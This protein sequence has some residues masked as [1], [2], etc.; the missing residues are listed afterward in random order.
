MARELDL[1]R[2]TV[3]RCLGQAARGTNGPGDRYKVAK[4]IQTEPVFCGFGRSAHSKVM[5]VSVQRGEIVTAPRYVRSKG[6]TGRV[7]RLLW[8]MARAGS[9]PVP[10]ES[11][12]APRW[13]SGH[14]VG[15]SLARDPA[16]YLGVYIRD[17][18]SI[19][20]V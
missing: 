2:K 18:P 10:T 9:A 6:R 7:V 19:D 13:I 1:D 14:G 5:S 12:E 4:C 3:R 8:R 15:Y 20:A 11:R 17:D 16:T